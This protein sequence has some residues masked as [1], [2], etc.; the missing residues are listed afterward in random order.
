MYNPQIGSEE[1][2]LLLSS[3]HRELSI[4]ER[5]A[6]NEKGHV[7]ERRMKPNKGF[8]IKAQSLIFSSVF[9]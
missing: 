3:S 4:P 6:G 8:L 5:E 1:G 9:I 2:L 7:E